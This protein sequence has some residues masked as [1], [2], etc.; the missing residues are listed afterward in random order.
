M[1]P[2]MFTCTEAEISFS[3]FMWN[4]PVAIEDSVVQ[5][6]QYEKEDHAVPVNTGSGAKFEFCT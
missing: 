1:T 2:E 3:G 5:S 4:V 6:S